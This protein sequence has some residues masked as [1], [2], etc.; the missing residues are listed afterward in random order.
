MEGAPTPT[1][2][3]SPRA[4][5]IGPV[6]RLSQ[7]RSMLTPVRQ[8]MARNR[9]TLS[10]AQR[11]S[12]CALRLGLAIELLDAGESNAFIETG[13]F[14]GARLCPMCEQRRARAWR[15]RM[16]QGLPAFRVDHPTHKALFLT[17]TVRN[18]PVHRLRDEVKHLHESFRRL[19]QCSFFPTA[20]WLRRTEVTIGAASRDEMPSGLESEGAPWCHPHLHCLLLVPARYFGPDYVKQTEWQRQWAMA[21]RLDYAPVVDV[22]RGYS[23]DAKSDPTKAMDSAAVEAAKYAVKATDINKLGELV[24]D[25]HEQLRGLHMVE[26]SRRLGQ[27]V[28]AKEIASAEMLDTTEVLTSTDPLLHC[29]A[30]WCEAD[31]KYSLTP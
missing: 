7:T 2:A 11:M 16:L 25:F 17:L 29:I 12:N 27:Y 9:Q 20:F 4:P 22:R 31:Q 1:L 3:P 14:C 5:I 30:Q 28:S 26:T 6:E 24:V 10:I 13:Y 19:R 21:A 23:K 18:V 15:R 8:V